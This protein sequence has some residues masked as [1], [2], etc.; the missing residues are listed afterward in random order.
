MKAMMHV[1]CLSAQ[2]AQEQLAESRDELAKCDRQRSQ[3]NNELERLQND[4]QAE[5]LRLKRDITSL[6]A[7]LSGFLLSPSSSPLFT[8]L[9]FSFR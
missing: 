3:A 6:N 4:D 1:P 2:A 9:F 5:Y 8:T 7:S